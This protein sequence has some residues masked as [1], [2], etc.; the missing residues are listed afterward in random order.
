VGQTRLGGKDGI[1]ERDDQSVPDCRI[2]IE[3]DLCRERAVRPGPLEWGRGHRC[4]QLV[5]RS[6]LEQTDDHLAQ[7]VE[8]EGH[9]SSL[10]R[11]MSMRSR[12]RTR[13][14][15]ERRSLS[16]RTVRPVFVVVLGVGAG[17]ALEVAAPEISSRSR[18]S[19][20]R[21]SATPV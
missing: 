2:R 15:G 4:R 20:R 16:K 17:H 3:P 14:L 11:T 18:H 7:L 19:R 8:F 21:M 12:R 6:R 9:V 1:E 13:S 5:R 10:I